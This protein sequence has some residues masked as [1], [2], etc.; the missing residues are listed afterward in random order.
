MKKRTQQIGRRRFIA[1]VPAAVA[2]GLALPTMAGAR[3]GQDNSS[4]KFGKDALKCAEQ[5]DGLHFTDGE[6]D[7]ALRGANRNLDSYEA[8]RHLDIPLDTDPAI[9]FRPYLPGKAPT[10]RSTRN[11]SLT[12]SRPSRAQVTSNLE[13]LA[14]EPTNARRSG[15]R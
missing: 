1:A 8:L 11:A 5:L 7:A 6:E 2:A 10:G 4:L 14:F 13:D 12:I 15:R 9:A 3:T